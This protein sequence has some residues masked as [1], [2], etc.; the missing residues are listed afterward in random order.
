MLPS[1][2][3]QFFKIQLKWAADACDAEHRLRL[4]AEER[5][6]GARGLLMELAMHLLA[7]EL[8]DVRKKQ[9]VTTWTDAQL[10][11][12]MKDQL[13][14]YLFQLRSLTG[15]AARRRLEQAA[16]EIHR[17]KAEVTQLNQQNQLLQAEAKRAPAYQ[18]T[19]DDLRQQ[20]DRLQRELAAGRDDLELSRSQTA[21]PVTP[22]TVIIDM[23]AEHEPFSQPQ[24]AVPPSVT[25]EWYAA[26]Q[27]DTSPEVLAR[28]QRLIQV[29]G[30]GEAFFRSE[31]VSALNAAG[32][33]KDDPD[34]PGGTAQ[35]LFTGLLE[36]DVIEEIDGGYGASVARPI[37]LTDQG[38]EA[39]RQFTGRAL[40]DSLYQRLLKR[41]KTIEHTVLN[42]MA[43]Q[44]MR[45]F[46]FTAIDLFP[47]PRRTPTGAVVIPDLTAVS[48]EGE[49]LLIECERLAKH[50]NAEE[51]RDKWGDLAALTQGQFY[52]VV[53]GSQQQRDLIT[54]I[55]QWIMETG[56]KRAHL[57]VCQYM[58]AIRS[59]VVRGP[60]AS[61]WPARSSVWAQSPTKTPISEPPTKPPLPN[62]LPTKTA[63]P[64][65]APSLTPTFTPRPTSTALPT[66]APPPSATASPTL[67]T[68]S[69]VPTA[70]PT[71]V[72]STSV[73]NVPASF[74]PTATPAALGI[75]G[76]ATSTPIASS[77]ADPIGAADSSATIA[78]PAAPVVTQVVNV[79]GFLLGLALLGLFIWFGL[80]RLGRAIT[81][82]IR[83]VSL[84]TLRLQHEAERLARREKMTFRAD[85]DML[86]LLEQAILDA[87]GESVQLRLLPNGWLA[88]PPM[89]AVV[90]ADQT[91]YIFSPLPPDQLRAIAHRQ[92][93]A[94]SLLGHATD[95]TA[96]PIDALNSTPFIADDLG[97][98]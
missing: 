66:P 69:P 27:Q 45:R 33:L 97:G 44:V 92:G 31:I 87:S 4:A 18:A 1:H 25:S 82:E 94:Q 41:H 15:D 68:P 13:G 96:Y 9:D 22:S 67:V 98:A 89:M 62:E 16:Q 14:N 46:H 54:E 88:A 56:T 75:I 34:R 8:D 93:L 59:A 79:G 24:P 52:V 17:L 63:V 50:R 76:S 30:E 48:P 84:A 21:R 61:L 26:W 49:L 70:T 39:Y 47:E 36:R 77:P 6:A 53:P 73:T 43:R 64:P 2:T 80:S 81:G 57:S 40:P 38:R 85:A 72:V 83:T 32:L 58:K 51:R 71:A 37:G 28:Q 5:A 42:L 95:L 29:V 55:S 12:W 60:I 19:I 74:T 10:V 65:E 90:D 3:E 11:R 86:S 91:R 23:P 20:I 7:A 35:R 78:D